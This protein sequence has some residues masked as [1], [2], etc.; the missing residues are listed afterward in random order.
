MT[1]KKLS[2]YT[3]SKPTLKIELLNSNNKIINIFLYTHCVQYLYAT[4]FD[5]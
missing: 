2:K 4:Q 1:I 5:F 3:K